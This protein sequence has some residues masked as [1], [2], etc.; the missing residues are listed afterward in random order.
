MREYYD[1]PPLF[2]P[3]STVF[4]VIALVKHFYYWY[5]R[6][7]YNYAN[8]LKRVFS[9]CE[10][11]ERVRHTLDACRSGCCAA[12]TGNCLARI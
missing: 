5:L 7:R 6:A 2:L 9:K 11:H 1:R 3:F 4:D 10:R 8:P 12:G